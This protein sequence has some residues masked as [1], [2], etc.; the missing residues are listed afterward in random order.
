MIYTIRIY[1]LWSASG[2]TWCEGHGVTWMHQAS[3]YTSRDAAIA[4]AR[5]IAAN[6]AD[7]LAWLSIVV[8]A[9]YPGSAYVITVAEWRNFSRYQEDA[10]Y[11]SYRA[12]SG[13]VV[14]ARNEAMIK[15]VLVLRDHDEKIKRA[16]EVSK[17][18]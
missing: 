9:H 1:A 6:W 5:D 7:D 17:T 14:T 12:L 15:G 4:I 2:G 10:C 13:A 16:Y 8:D 3:Q 18:V 11:I